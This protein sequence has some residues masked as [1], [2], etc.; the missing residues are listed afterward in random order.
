MGNQI[1]LEQITN[2]VHK[3]QLLTI[4]DALQNIYIDTTSNNV[5]R[6]IEEWEEL[7]DRVVLL[8]HTGECFGDLIIR[9]GN[10]K[11]RV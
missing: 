11:A 7:K 4:T 10:K 8:I 6:H 5:I 9:V 3:D 1:T 2:M